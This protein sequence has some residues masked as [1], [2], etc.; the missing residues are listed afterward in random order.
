VKC[1]CAHAG[2]IELKRV[3]EK[4]KRKITLSPAAGTQNTKSRR[5]VERGADETKAGEK[6]RVEP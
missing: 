2:G 6:A 5:G 4:R 3:E 1:T